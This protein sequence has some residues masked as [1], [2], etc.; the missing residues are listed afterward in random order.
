MRKGTHHSEET[1][2]KMMGRIV[3]EETRRKISLAKK[4]QVSW[5][6]GK[7]PS[8]ETRKKMS[9]SKKGKTTWIK[10]LTKETDERVMK[11]SKAGKGRPSPLRG[12]SRSEETKRKISESHKGKPRSLETRRKIGESRI[13]IIAWNKGK[14]NIYSEETKKKMSESAKERCNKLGEKEKFRKTMSKIV[15]PLKDTK[16]EVKIQNLL[17]QLGYDFLTHKY[18]KEI[19]HAYQCDVLIPSLNLVIECDG[20]YWHNYPIGNERDH[21][22]TK[23]LIE[24][25]FKVLRLWERD[26]K[27]MDLNAFSILL[28]TSKSN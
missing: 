14:K 27:V 21:I 6:K 10:G 13:G 1:K 25:G 3:S 24:K 15:L 19:E 20:D 26:I 2:K 28:S 18:I 23:E 16:I 12:I 5:M 4:G 8:L 7:H 22:R 9:E 11:I 17:K